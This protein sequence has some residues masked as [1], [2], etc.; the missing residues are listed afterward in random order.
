MDVED[1]EQAQQIIQTVSQAIQQKVHQR[2]A[3]IVTKCLETV[4]DDPY[5][6]KIVFE[7]S[8]GKTEAR[9]LFVRNG[10]EVHPLSA[11]GGGV[12][13]VAAFALRLACLLMSRPR[14]R[15][16]MILDEP[17]RFV[18]LVGQQRIC[19]LLEILAKEMGVQ[20]VMVTHEDELESGKVVILSQKEHNP[21]FDFQVDV[22]QRKK[23]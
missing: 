21:D 4:F 19:Q 10:L 8:R 23:R 1:H 6:F 15:K 18:D 9:L 11:S 2:I 17:F 5:Q 16:L 14:S 7:Q 13:D 20:F 22:K 3:R 12:V